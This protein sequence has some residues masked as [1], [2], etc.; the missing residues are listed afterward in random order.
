MMNRFV[1]G[2]TFLAAATAS[3]TAF[4]A[5]AVGPIET[6]SKVISVAGNGHQRTFPCNGRKVII[7]GS[8]HVITLTGVCSGLELTGVDNTVTIALTPNAVLEV[9][10][11]GQ[12]V[13]WASSGEPRQSISGVDN[14]ISRIKAL[15]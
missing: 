4:S 15:P 13:Q 7:H 12:K 5:E 14:K 3:G 1:R 9:A 8:E 10:G 2:L 6:D 11:T